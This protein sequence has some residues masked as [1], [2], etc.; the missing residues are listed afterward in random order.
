M[1]SMVGGYPAVERATP[2]RQ[3]CAVP[4]PLAGEEQVYERGGAVESRSIS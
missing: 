1:R 3:G 4:P 2:L